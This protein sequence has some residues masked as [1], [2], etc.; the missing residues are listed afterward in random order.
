[1]KDFVSKQDF[2]AVNAAI[3]TAHEILAA[4]TG[5]GADFTGWYDW[6][7]RFDK[8]EFARIKAAAKKIQ[9]E[10][11]VLVVVGI[12][13][14]YLGAR[15]A[16]EF[17][18][19]P[20]YNLIHKDTPEIYFA[21]N[22]MSADQLNEI[23]SII[24]DRD[25][26][27]NV[28]SKSGTTIEPALAF[29]VLKKLLIAKYGEKQANARIYATTGKKDKG[30]RHLA[31]VYG[32]ET[33]NVPDD[34]GGRFSVLTAVG[35]L[36][37]A[38][39]GVDIDA[40][41]NGAA[42]AMKELSVRSMDN[43]AWQYAAARQALQRSG[44]VTEIMAAY[45]PRYHYVSEWWK[46]LYGESEG[47]QQGGIFPASVDLSSDLHSMGQYIQEGRRNIFET[48]MDIEN[49][50]SELKISEDPDNIDELNFAAGM[51][52]NYINH[53]AMAGVVIAHVDGGVPNIKIKLPD[54]SAKTFGYLVYFFELACGISG[55]VQGINPFDQPGVE[56]YKKNMF[57]LL[58]KP[59]YEEIREKLLGRI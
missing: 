18:T 19:S 27:V 24:G 30:L 29:R 7:E 15:A 56:A 32:Y 51:S 40:M 44:K 49:T 42:I 22:N 46:Q 5:A 8:D 28:I 39:A 36:P 9:S 35:L 59:G 50:A 57:A 53:Q 58:G 1:M 41:M 14:S 26:S 3:P 13:G 4:K 23:I 48:V 20:N 38:V 55:Y 45:E 47:K 6:P 16:I 12:G 52:M 11:K 54:N 37:I 17:V 21:G 33:F 10:S 2:D 25:F 34:I 31:N 43:A